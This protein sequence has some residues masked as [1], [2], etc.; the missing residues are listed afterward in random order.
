GACLTL[1]QAAFLAVLARILQLGSWQLP[2]LL[3]ATGV[4]AL[5]WGLVG[6]ALCRTG[7]GAVLVGIGLLGV[8]WAAAVFLALGVTLPLWLRPILTVFAGFYARKLF[9]AEDVS[10]QTAQTAAI[11][12]PSSLGAV[13]WL[14]VRQGRLLIA[15][16]AAVCVIV[17]V[18]VPEAQWLWV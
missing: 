13:L 4:D 15:I 6:S 10:R 7:W 8:T 16:S 5:V 2:L 3:A 11:S 9:C 12:R 17:G 1:A 14:A 18:A